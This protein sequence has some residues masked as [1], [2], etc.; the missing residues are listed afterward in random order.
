[1]IAHAPAAPKRSGLPWYVGVADAQDPGEVGALNIGHRVANQGA[2]NRPGVSG[3]KP[4]VILPATSHVRE[5]NVSD[6]S[7]GLLAA[8][9]TAMSA[10][11]GL[12]HGDLVWVIIADASAATLWVAYVTAPSVPTI[13]QKS[14]SGVT[15]LQRGG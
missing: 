1:M 10:L 3:D 9:G 15:W 2:S 5:L 4:C 12:A 13:A 6:H 8:V 7:G 11:V 14:S